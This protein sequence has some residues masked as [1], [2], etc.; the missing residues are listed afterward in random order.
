MSGT[1][2]VR[3]NASE[4]AGSSAHGGLIVIEGDA[5]SRAGISLK[6]GT[7]AVA[8][9][10]GHMSGFMAQAGTI[11]IGGDAGDALGDSLYEAVIYVA[12]QIRSLGADAQV[13]ELTDAGR[14]PGPRARGGGGLRAHPG[15]GRHPGRLGAHAVPLRRAQGSEV[16]M[17]PWTEPSHTF[18]AEVIGQIHQMA[19]EGRY[20]IRGWGAKRALPTFDDLVFLTASLTRYPLEGYRERCETTT[21]LGARHASQPARAGHPDH[22]RRDELRRAVGA[23][24]GGPGPGGHRRRH[25]HHHRRRRDDAGGA[26][27]L[28]AARLPVPAVPL[29]LQPR[30]TCAPPTR[31]R[32]SSARAPSPAAAACCSARRSASGWPPCAPCRPASTSGRPAGTRT[33]PVPT[34]C[35]SRSRSCARPPTGRCRSTSRSARPGSS[36]TS[37]WPWRPAP[38][39]WWSTACRAA[40][41][42]TQ[43]VFI[44]HAGIPTLPAVR[45]AAEALRDI[46]MAATRSSWSSR[47]A[48]APAP[49]WPRRWPWARTPSPSAWAR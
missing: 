28:P 9:D 2:R 46:G 25:L 22:D 33:G 49:T 48:S 4:A 37:S 27:G 21:V 6:G 3:G 43:D 5:S 44:E 42:A 7:V 47:A 13:E 11:L 40:P 14:G 18:P 29:R 26:Q 39:S 10:V 19:D 30:R 32:S 23:G 1:L 20:A 31:S 38:T 41:A 36:T 12:G 45:L 8:G 16:L 24:Q 15:R 17:D 34:T 35:A